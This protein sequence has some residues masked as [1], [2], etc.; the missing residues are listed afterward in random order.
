MIDRAQQDRRRHRIVDDQRNAVPVR[1]LGQRLDVA[2][3]AGR[4][5][6]AFAEHGARALVDQLL[7]RRRRVG[8]GKPHIDALPR[9]QM[10]EQRMRRAI[11]LRHRHDVAAELRDVERRVIQGRLPGAHAQ[12]FQAALE[13]GDAPLEHGVGGVA[14]PAVAMSL[15]LEIEQRRPVLGAVER[16]GHGLI[17]RDRHGLRGRLDVVA[18]MDRDGLAFHRFTWPFVPG[19]QVTAGRCAPAAQH[20]RSA[21]SDVQR[22]RLESDAITLTIDAMTHRRPARLREFPRA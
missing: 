15:G 8:L 9:Q 10:G 18:A 12:G 22:S 7:D 4:I 6:D 14:D 17:D 19:R 16:I 3:V 1:D 13:G 2:D 5:A 11:E 21:A 20:G